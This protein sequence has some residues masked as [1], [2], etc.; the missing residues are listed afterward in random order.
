MTPSDLTVWRK[1][2]GLNKV[3]AAEALGV[4]RN[5]VAD[6]EAGRYPIPLYIDLACC[7]LA[8]VNETAER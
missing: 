3:Q 1:R 6:Y 4:N 2:L 7:W 5:T 8:H